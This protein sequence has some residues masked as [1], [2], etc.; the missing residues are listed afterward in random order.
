MKKTMMMLALLFAVAT[1]MKAQDA[2]PQDT[3]PLY[4]GA[5]VDTFNS[6]SEE[7]RP[8]EEL[9]AKKSLVTYREGKDEVTGLTLYNV[10]VVLWEYKN[11]PGEEEDM[12]LFMN[13][14]RV[15]IDNDDQSYKKVYLHK[16][17]GGAFKMSVLGEDY[18]M[19]ENA[20]TNFLLLTVKH[21]TDPNLKVTYAINIRDDASGT[22]SSCTLYRICEPIM[23][24]LSVMREE[25]KSKMSVEMRP[26]VAPEL[27][28]GVYVKQVQIREYKALL[29]NLNED[30]SL[31]ELNKENANNA[32]ERKA[33]QKQINQLRK[34]CVQV[35]D[36]IGQLISEI[37][38][39][40]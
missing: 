33:C 38:I 29:K 8:F 26:I 17:V 35:Y 34:Q 39:L 2:N 37:S 14:L 20:G 3:M 28:P 36:K 22:I 23:G 5:M 21:A 40:P 32:K 25:P 12:K 1:G 7:W 11:Q 13:I 19:R 10:K 18:V 24:G 27:A 9:M 31:L 6:S 16:G 4:K 15:M 30:I